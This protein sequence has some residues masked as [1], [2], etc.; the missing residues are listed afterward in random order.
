[1]AAFSTGPPQSRTGAAVDGGLTCTACHRTF[2]PA[3]SDPRGT[4]TMKVAP[5]RPGVTQTITIT[6][7]H[8]DQKRWGYQLS[9]R[10]ASNVSKQ[11][12]TFTATPD[13]RVRCL[14]G[15]DAPCLGGDVEFVSHRAAP[16]T[17]VG[18][19]YT[20][21]VDW[22]PPTRAVGDIVFYLAGNAADGNGTNANDRIYNASMVVPPAVCNIPGIPT[23]TSAVSSASFTG[24]LAPNSLLS[25]FGTGFQSTGVTRQ[26]MA[27][28]LSAKLVPQALSCVAV[29]VNKVRAPILYAS[30]TQINAVVPTGTAAGAADVRV[31]VNPT[32]IVPFSSSPVTVQAAAAAPTLFTLD[33]SKVIAQISGTST[34]VADSTAVKGA[35]AAK[36]GDSITLY[37]S[38]LGDTAAHLDAAALATAASATVN[39]VTVMLG[40]KALPPASVTYA[41][42]TPGMTAGLYQINVTLPAGIPAGDTSL[43]VMVNGAASQDGVTILTVAQ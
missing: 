5:W 15:P 39:P 35:R 25:I 22:T 33:G 21:S 17:A 27:E 2:A 10:L 42:V 36:P 34:L 28:D 40:G 18:A 37:A 8:P 38:G 11:A 31:I 1:M 19:G 29:E 41:G 26:V 16:V 24:S 3:N 4:L 23:I 32:G 30:A 13:N 20:F 43:K 6:I 7:N 9:S 12:G 14:A